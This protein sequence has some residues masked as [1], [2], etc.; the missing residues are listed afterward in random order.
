MAIAAP[1]AVPTP[2]MRARFSAIAVLVVGVGISSFSLLVGLSTFGRPGSFQATPFGDIG[3]FV[4]AVTLLALGFV[5]RSRRP[6]NTIGALFLAFGICAT[7][8][9][10]AWAVMQAG[11]QPGGD[12]RLGAIGAWLGMV[13]SILTWTYLLISVIIRFPDGEPATP[14]EARVLRWL[15]AFCVVAAATAALRPGPLLI[16]LAFDNPVSTPTNLHGLLTIASSIG[17]GGVLAPG[18]IAGAAIVRRYRAATNVERLQLRW[19]ALGASVAVIASATY[20]VFGVVV[21]PENDFVREVT[22]ALF[23]VSLAGL[24]IAVF[25]A[26]TTHRLYDIDR[27]I[28]RA[29][30]Y[31][32]LT[33]ILAG[34]YSASVRLFNWVF[35]SVTGQE[36]EAALV[37]TTLVLATSFTPIKSALERLATRRFKFDAAPTDAAPPAGA[38]DATN[39]AAGPFTPAQLA[40][41]DARIAAALERASAGQDRR[42]PG[43]GPVG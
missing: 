16:F 31:G 9:H 20:L 6:E 29:F 34:L 26:I 11:Y 43:E 13:G 23:V 37:L 33:A 8:A 41:I 24:P 19:F 3:A 38:V 12:P 17:L 21:A 15:P 7:L 22:Y 32:A 27:I 30:A 28:G 4:F 1:A 14:G 2:S 35:V 36:S 18:F 5:L 42:R 25:H 40:T 10:L 39:A